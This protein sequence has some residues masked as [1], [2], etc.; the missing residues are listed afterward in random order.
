MLAR[1]VVQRDPDGTWSVRET[2]TNTPAI[3]NSEL[4]VGLTEARAVIRA[5]KLNSRI[6]EA[7][8]RSEETTP[9]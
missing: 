1:Y 2:S 3:V 7:D 5:G 9:L 4:Q 8:H 6:I